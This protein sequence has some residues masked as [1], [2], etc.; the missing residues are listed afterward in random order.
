ME[1]FEDDSQMTLCVQDRSR[2]RD[3]MLHCFLAFKSKP[4]K[5]Y[6][7]HY[8]F[9]TH[10]RKKLLERHKWFTAMQMFFKKKRRERMN[11]DRDALTAPIRAFVTRRLHPAGLWL[12]W[13][14]A[15]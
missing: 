7:V 2:V 10:K 15:L 13:L 9:H 3:H 1:S 4:L 11:Y 6:E 8:L 14:N 12:A 5:F